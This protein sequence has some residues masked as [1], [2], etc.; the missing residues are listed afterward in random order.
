LYM[1]Q[2]LLDMAQI[3][4]DKFRKNIST[5]DIKNSIRAILSIQRLKAKEKN[6]QLPI[7]FVGMDSTETYLVTS[8]E[9]RIQ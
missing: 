8:D 3:K 7:E 6:V 9:H 2:D 1:V 4:S 5:F